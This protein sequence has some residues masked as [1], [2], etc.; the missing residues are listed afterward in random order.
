MHRPGWGGLCWGGE[1]G[2]VPAPSPPPP[3]LRRCKSVILRLSHYRTSTSRRRGAGATVRRSQNCRITPPQ[4]GRCN[5]VIPLVVAVVMVVMGGGVCNG[6]ILRSCDHRSFAGGVRR[7]DRGV[8]Y[9][10]PAIVAASQTACDGAIRRCDTAIVA[11]SQGGCDG[12]MARR[13]F[14]MA[15][16]VAP[17]QNSRRHATAR[18]RDARV[19]WRDAPHRRKI[20][21]GV[22]SSQAAVRNCDASQW[23]FVIPR[24]DCATVR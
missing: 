4:P 16:R 2:Y 17:S 15:Q 18:W 3:Q 11:V 14:A 24:W 7:C 1:E 12:A 6:A 13:D 5:S 21:A 9:C 20:T 23:D 22:R 19:R 8:R 10:D